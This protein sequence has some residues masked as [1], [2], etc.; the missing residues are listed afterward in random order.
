MLHKFADFVGDDLTQNKVVMS[1]KCACKAAMI[2]I[3][4][5]LAQHHWQVY[6]DMEK[7][8]KL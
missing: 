3:V 7:Q 1:N 8:P 4:L 2:K 5:P 6:E